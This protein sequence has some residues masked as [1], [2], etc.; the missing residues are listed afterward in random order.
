MELAVLIHLLWLT[1]K[2]LNIISDSAYVIG[3]FPATDSVR[4]HSN[5][6]SFIAKGNKQAGA[7]ICPISTSPDADG[8]TE[9]CIH[10]SLASPAPGHQG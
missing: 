9:T 2:L 8:S 10:S 6:L 5:F 1:H 7:L 4:A 3:L